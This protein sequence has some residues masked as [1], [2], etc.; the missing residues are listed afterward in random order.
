MKKKKKINNLQR[1]NVSSK[2]CS[3]MIKIFLL[4]NVSS[5][6]LPNCIV[7]NQKIKIYLDNLNLSYNIAKKNALSYSLSLSLSLSSLGLW[8]IIETKA[9]KL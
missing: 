8:N 9:L 2:E 4:E 5:K 1:L 7:F 6:I 3:M